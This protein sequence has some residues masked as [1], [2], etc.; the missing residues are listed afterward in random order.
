METNIQPFFLLHK[1]RAIEPVISIG[2]SSSIIGEIY[3][4]TL[5]LLLKTPQ[6]PLKRRVLPC[7]YEHLCECLLQLPL[8]LLL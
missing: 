1:R 6:T 8:S 7:A 2:N 5:R 4:D 3:I